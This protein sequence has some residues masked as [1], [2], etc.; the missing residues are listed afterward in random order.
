MKRKEPLRLDEV[1]RRMIE[2][3]GMRPELERRTAVTMWP[4]I[5]GDSIA[6]YT[7]RIYVQDRVLHVFLSS[8]PLKEELGYARANL[9]DR[10]N[11]A[12]G[13]D[14]IDQIIIH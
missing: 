2:Q 4:R 7:S 3:T 9:T 12:V 5:V 11:Q 10:I 14:V 6:A 13:A 8:A 1:I